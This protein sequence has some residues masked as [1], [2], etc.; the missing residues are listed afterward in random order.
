MLN[1]APLGKTLRLPLR[2][3]AKSWELSYEGC[4]CNALFMPCLGYVGLSHLIAWLMICCLQPF[5]EDSLRLL[6]LHENLICSCVTCRSIAVSSHIIFFIVPLLLALFVHLLI[7]FWILSLKIM[8]VFPSKN[9]FVFFVWFLT[10]YLFQV[11]S[12]SHLAMLVFFQF[13]I[14]V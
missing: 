5:I 6:Y 1:L 14:I 7:I 11:F 2:A 12:L 9:H 13:I 4:Y 10:L 8:L 3:D